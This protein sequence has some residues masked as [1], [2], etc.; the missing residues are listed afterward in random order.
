VY[1]SLESNERDTLIKLSA[2]MFQNTSVGALAQV[3]LNPEKFRFIDDFQ[4][5]TENRISMSVSIR[6]LDS[7][8]KTFADC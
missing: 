2:I 6:V 3:F 1:C 4:D 8:R 7:Q 5:D